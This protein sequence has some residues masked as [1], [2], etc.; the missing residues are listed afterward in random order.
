[1]YPNSQP[2]ADQPLSAQPT[3]HHWMK[4]TPNRIFVPGRNWCVVVV[5]W[6]LRKQWNQ[7]EKVVVPTIL[8]VKK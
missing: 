3:H 5:A 7:Q 1:M 8:L 6:S 4:N 2:N